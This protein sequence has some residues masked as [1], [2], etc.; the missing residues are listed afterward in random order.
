MMRL[1][2]SVHT[3]TVLQMQTQQLIDIGRPAPN[4][5]SQPPQLPP[6][7]PQPPQCRLPAGSLYVYFMLQIWLH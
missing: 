6:Q 2:R 5:V 4:S 1:A 7:L 3:A